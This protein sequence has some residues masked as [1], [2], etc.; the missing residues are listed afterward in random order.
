MRY[1]VFLGERRKQLVKVPLPARR[2][3]AESVSPRFGPIQNV[4]DPP[5][6]PARGLRFLGPD[7]LKDFQDQPGI[8]VLNG[9]GADNRI[10]VALKRFRP[11]LGVRGAPPARFMGLDVGRR[12]LRGL[13]HRVPQSRL[14]QRQ[15]HR[16]VD[17]HP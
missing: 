15:A 4:L 14:A 3:L 16:A 8:N 11:L 12:A 10:G 13:L 9:Q 5:A 17:E 1:P 6:Q 7:R 2:I